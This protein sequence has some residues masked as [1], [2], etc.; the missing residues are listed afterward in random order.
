MRCLL[1]FLHKWDVLLTFLYIFIV[2]YMV[3]LQQWQNELDCSV[4]PKLSLSLLT[5]HAKKILVHMGACAFQFSYHSCFCCYY[6]YT[7]Q[8]WLQISPAL[9]AEGNSV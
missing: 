9:W 1:S 7:T 5:P 2:L 4:E 3:F 6:F 8:L